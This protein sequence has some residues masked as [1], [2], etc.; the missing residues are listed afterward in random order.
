MN[1]LDR[2]AEVRQEAARVREE[3]GYPPLV[4]PT[5]QIVGVQAVQNVLIGR[6]KLVSKEARE[7]ISGGYG[8]PPAQIAPD[9]QKAILRDKEPMTCRPADLLEPELEKAREESKEFAKNIQDVL[10]YALY[11]TTGA[12]FLKYKYGIDKTI[13]DDWK[14]PNAPKALEE[15]EREDELIA[16]VK[17]GKLKGS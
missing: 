12:R 14:P 8:R 6:Y 16:Q 11:P 15:V 5:S 2:L 3:F 9:I 1:A 17:A 10:I 7:Y 4:T 13:P